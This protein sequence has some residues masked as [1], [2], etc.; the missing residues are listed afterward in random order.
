MTEADVYPLLAG[1]AGGRVYPYVVPLNPQGEPAVTA[2]WVVFSIIA[3]VSAEV[4]C[5]P[6]EK[7]ASLQVDVYASTIDEARL[8]REEVRSALEPLGYSDM[9]DT[10][11]YEPDTALYRAMLD[12]RIIN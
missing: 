3:E 12:V 2:P 4:L 11:G 6:A 1:I 9:N 7:T 5:G 8:I 10:N